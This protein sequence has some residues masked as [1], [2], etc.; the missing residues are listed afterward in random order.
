MKKNFIVAGMYSMTGAL[1]LVCL[2]ACSELSD[3]QRPPNSELPKWEKQLQHAQSLSAPEGY[4][5][6]TLVSYK[7]LGKI[8]SESEKELLIDELFADDAC[9]VFAQSADYKLYDIVTWGDFRKVRANAGAAARNDVTA[10]IKVGVTEVIELEWS[11][12]GQTYHTKALADETQ[13]GIT[14]D[15]IATYVPYY[16]E[17]EKTPETKTMAKVTRQGRIL[18]V[19]FSKYDMEPTWLG[20]IKWYYEITCTSY[21]DINTGLLYDIKAE[22]KHQSANGWH[23]DARIMTVA[24]EIGKSDYHKF[25]WAWCADTE[26][27]LIGYGGSGF[28]LTGSGR[29]ECGIEIHRSPEPPPPTPFE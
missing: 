15:N 23:V 29:G 9:T 26:G 20:G 6:L 4:D 28:N 1:A 2:I 25:A 12:R 19:P 3:H 7:N 10:D 27:V 18:S 17:V 21:F 8:G 5:Q 22:A 14:Y 13:D 24:G 16:G 11:Y